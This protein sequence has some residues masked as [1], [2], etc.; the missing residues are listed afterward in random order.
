MR[1]CACT[2]AEESLLSRISWAQQAAARKYAFINHVSPALARLSTGPECATERLS[3]VR[4]QYDNWHL[5]MILA[6]E[7]LI[8]LNVQAIWNRSGG[9]RK[10]GAI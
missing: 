10:P 5:G 9:A 2:N 7:E 3:L 6:R 4:P 8:T 1:R